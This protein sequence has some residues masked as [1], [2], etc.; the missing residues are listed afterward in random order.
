MLQ[1]DTGILL[2]EEVAKE[3]IAK[4]TFWINK[5][6][7]QAFQGKAKSKGSNATKVLLE[8]I[9]RYLDRISSVK[10]ESPQVIAIDLLN[11]LQELRNLIRINTYEITEKTGDCLT[12]LRLPIE[13]SNKNP[14]RVG[15]DNL[16]LKEKQPTIKSNN[17]VKASIV[18]K[19]K[20]WQ[21][22]QQKA[23]SQNSSAARE[24]VSFVDIYLGLFDVA[25]NENTA[26]VA[27]EIL[28][29][30]QKLRMLIDSN[31]SS[32]KIADL[33]DQRL[34]ILRPSSVIEE[35]K[36]LKRRSIPQRKQV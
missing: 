2:K 28:T 17:S 36:P 6:I 11:E 12:L 23:K 32:V 18:L 33:T 3:E 29:E 7:W 30:L 27:Q 21:E 4:A 5:D 22:F 26:Y 31:S 13:K 19:Q 9:D 35:D 16:I 34:A 10:A 1:Q 8:F 15:G 14:K 25:K 20:T 24:L